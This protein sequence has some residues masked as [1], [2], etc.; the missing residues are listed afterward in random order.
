MK[1]E[2]IFLVHVAM[3]GATLMKGLRKGRTGNLHTSRIDQHGRISAEDTIRKPEANLPIIQPR[4][5]SP[6]NDSYFVDKLQE[7]LLAGSQ[8][9]TQ[10]QT[11]NTRVNFHVVTVAHTAPGHSQRKEISPGSAGCY[12]KEYKLKYVKFFCHSIVFC[13]SCNKCHSCCP[14]SACRGETSKFLANLAGSGCQSESSSNPERGLHPPLSDPAKLGKVSN[15][16]KLLCQSAQEPLPAGS[17]TSAYRQKCSR[18]SG[19]S[20]ISGVFQPTISSTQIHQQVEAYTRC[21]Q[22]KSFPQGG[23]IQNGDTRNHQDIPPTR[24]VGYLNRL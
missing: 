6:T 22:T 24:G 9:S 4:A 11:M 7:G 17:I 16:H 18:A 1:T 2:G 10:G 20:E 8:I 14:K 21:E 3:V 13:K 15:S 19:Q 12:Q 23:K 5:S